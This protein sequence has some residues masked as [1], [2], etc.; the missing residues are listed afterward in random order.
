VV[1]ELSASYDKKR[2]TELINAAFSENPEQ[3][4][5]DKQKNRVTLSMLDQPDWRDRYA[6]MDRMDPTIEDLPVLDKALEDDRSSIR[7]LATAYL[8]M[9]EEIGRASCRERV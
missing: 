9:I 5:S 3:L 8:G 6:A 7:R 4:S 2:L 1:E